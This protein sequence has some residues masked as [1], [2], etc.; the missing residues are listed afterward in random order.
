MPSKLLSIKEVSR[1]ELLNSGHSACAGCGMVIAVRQALKVFGKNTVVVTPAGCLPAVAC[2][3]FGLAS[4]GVPTITCAFEAAGAFLSGI[5][6]TLTLKGMKDGINVVG[7]AGDG[8]TADIGIQALS[9]AFERGHSII[10]LCYDNEAYQ[11]TGNQRSGSTPYGASTS[12]TPVGK[13][14]TFKRQQKKDMPRIM[15]AH[16][17]PYVA[18]ASI[19]YP[20]DYMG[21]VRRAVELQGPAYIQVHSPCPTGWNFP[22]DK[23]VEIARLAVL[24]GLWR[25]YEIEDGQFR[26]TVKVARRRPVVDYLKL[27]RRFGHLSPEDTDE[28]QRSVDDAWTSIGM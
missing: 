25:L 28:I 15:A 7:I 22:S 20:L 14:R 5:E 6:S 18:T 8:G 16:G 2:G 17:I 24:T 26:M 1:D 10:Y 13:V 3:P 4:F 11:N 21:K 12:T 23:T 27:Q 9:G 19:A